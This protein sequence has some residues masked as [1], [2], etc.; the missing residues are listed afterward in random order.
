MKTI[1]IG[2]GAGYSGDRIEPA[3]DIMQR[4]N[5]DYI[6]FEC[7]AERTIA[8]AQKQRLIDPSKGYNELLEYR[9]KAILPIC[10]EKKVKIITNMG[11]ANPLA[12]VKV[13]KDLAESL[14]IKNLKIAAVLG[15]DVFDN[16]DKYL[17]YEIME[18]GNKLKSIESQIVS[19]NAYIGADGIAEALRNGADIVITGRVAD[20]SLALGP[21]MYEFGWKKEDYRLLGKGTL[22]GHLL[23]CASQ[24]MGG[25]YA[26]PGYKNVP[27]L[28]NIGFPIGEINEEGDVII[29]KLEESGGMVTVDTCK[30]QILYE[31]QDPENYYTPNVVADFS[32]VTVEQIE[33][34]KV[35]I[36]SASGKEKTGFF[37]TSIG[38]KDCFIGEGEIS[39]G[40]SGAYERTKL[41]GDIIKRRLEYLNVPIEELR[42]DYIGVNSLYKDFLSNTITDGKNDFKEVRLRVAARTLNK[43]EAEIIG[44]EVEALYTN[45]PA[46]GG[47]VRKYVSEVVSIASILIPENDTNIKVVYEEICL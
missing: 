17:E 36:K 11:A 19:A 35:L 46:G 1:R 2:S 5:L 12:A 7:L 29:T 31:I 28:W 42:I 8:L 45:G 43:E 34:D 24:V 10:I 27:D 39:Y 22:A 30:E 14:G 33:K 3:I 18:T 41:A 32:K 44:N 13:T 37:K 4:G 16:I 9:M 25:Y 20:P 38:Y 40:G 21:L 15:D 23:E 6:I 26:D 47:G